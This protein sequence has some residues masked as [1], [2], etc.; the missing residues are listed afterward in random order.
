MRG[1]TSKC[2]TEYIEFNTWTW[3]FLYGFLI[4]C[5]PP[6]TFCPEWIF[7]LFCIGQNTIAVKIW[8][9][10][11]KKFQSLA[12][13]LWPHVSLMFDK[14]V[15]GWGQHW[16]LVGSLIALRWKG[17]GRES[18]RDALLAAPHLA[19]GPGD[20]SLCAWHPWSSLDRLRA[21]NRW[22]FVLLWV[23]FS[24][25]FSR[26]ADSFHTKSIIERQSYNPYQLFGLYRVYFTHWNSPSPVK[27]KLFRLFRVGISAPAVLR[28]GFH[29]C[30]KYKDG[31]GGCD[32][33]L[34][35]HGM[36]VNLCFGYF[37][38]IWIFKLRQIDLR[39]AI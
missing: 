26:N 15:S 18:R 5:H 31:T 21:P 8:S 14:R 37:C 7:G 6:N 4:L 10:N 38:S 30:L 20:K 19:P 23:Y 36:G 33:C 9:N 32:G 28:L 39:Q 35:W 12:S 13:L 16:T 24:L 34:N 11:E 27:A 17:S 1:E 3:Y 2:K 22:L 25:K 29:D